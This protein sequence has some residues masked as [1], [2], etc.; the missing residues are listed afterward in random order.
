MVTIVSA[1]SVGGLVAG[2]LWWLCYRYVALGDSLC[3]GVGSLTFYGYAPRLALAL[4][5]RLRRLVRL[6]NLGR[7]GMSSAQLLE[8]LQT[9]PRF[10]GALKAASLITVNI[11]GN[12][13][14]A[15]DYAPGC[16]ENAIDRFAG[17]WDAI[18]AELRTLNPEAILLVQ[19]VYNP[20]PPAHPM[21]NLATQFV[22]QVNLV[23]ANP[24]LAERYRVHGIGRVY[25]AFVGNECEYTWFC[26]FGDIHPTDRGHA[27]I[28]GALEDAYLAGNQT[29]VHAK[30]V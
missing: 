1:A 18:L 9:D 11:G 26:L 22:S 16:L 10:R 29:K 2:L 13:L 7:F 30:G 14:R 17:N 19:T 28:A 6:T 21:H 3:A 27:A 12:D 25:E 5:R 24:S 8:A 20:I 15:C 4:T 23:I